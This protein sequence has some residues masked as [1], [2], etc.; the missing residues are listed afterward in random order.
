MPESLHKI[1]MKEKLLSKQHSTFENCFI[2]K[3]NNLIIKIRRKRQVAMSKIRG[4]LIGD[5]ME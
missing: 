5:M 1:L 4:E 3:Q 2:G